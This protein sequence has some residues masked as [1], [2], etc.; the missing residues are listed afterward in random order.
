MLSVQEW[1]MV[2]EG[3]DTYS[4][5]PTCQAKG[6]HVISTTA[7]HQ[8]FGNPTRAVRFFCEQCQSVCD[9]PALSPMPPCPIPEQ[10]LA[11]MRRIPAGTPPLLNRPV[12]FETLERCRRKQP[13]GRAPGEDG[14]PR[15]FCKYG[16]L[17]LLELYWKATNAFLKGDAP[18]VCP[19]EWTGAVAGQI[20]K[21]LSA[22]LMTELRPIACICTK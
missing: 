14:I 12:G 11:E 9:E 18:S 2:S 15:E 19:S 10:V 21:A 20:P 16:P 22:L 6:L 13:N 5:C 3:M 8:R 4:V 1:H 7:T 17:A